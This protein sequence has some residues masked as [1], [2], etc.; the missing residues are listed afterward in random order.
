M[1][2]KTA[3]LLD[4]IRDAAVFIRQVTREK[5]DADY[6]ADRLLRQAVERNF[7]IIG[8]AMRRLEAL[9]PE[10]AAQIGAC[11]SRRL[12]QQDAA[13]PSRGIS[14][15]RIDK[16]SMRARCPTG[17]HG[18]FVTSSVVLRHPLRFDA[19]HCR[20]APPIAVLRHPLRFRQSSRQRF[21]T[22]GPAALRWSF[23]LRH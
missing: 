14:I 21:G 4:D 1:P 3:K 10:I 15:G 22:C 20:S 7:E 8:E 6:G 2:P 23:G 19:T 5:T 16:P 18:R 13:S 12:S 11:L 9:A 17:L